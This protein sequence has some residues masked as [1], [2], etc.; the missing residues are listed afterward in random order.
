MKKMFFNIPFQ[1]PLRKIDYTSLLSLNFLIFCFLISDYRN[2]SPMLHITQI[3][4]PSSH[5]VSQTSIEK[6]KSFSSYYSYNMRW[7][8]L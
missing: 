6:L 8:R 7:F 1:F 4:N 2:N 5:V 3:M